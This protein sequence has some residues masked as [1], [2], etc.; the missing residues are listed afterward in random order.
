MKFSPHFYNRK[1]TP[2][3]P[4]IPG[5]FLVNAD[6]LV[7]VGT[8]D[9]D[10][11]PCYQFIVVENIDILAIMPKNEAKLYCV[12][13]NLYRWDGTKLIQLG[14]GNIDLEAVRQ[15]LTVSRSI[16]GAK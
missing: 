13:T 12:D 16:I 2:S 5:E 3:T 11:F 9:G 1:G 10:Y 8:S 6:G 7:Y 4:A 14:G 15:G